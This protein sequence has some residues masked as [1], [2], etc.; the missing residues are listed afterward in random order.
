ML[1]RNTVGSDPTEVDPTIKIVYIEIDPWE[2][3][4]KHKPEVFEMPLKTI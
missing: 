2:T 3:D 4:Y 1:V